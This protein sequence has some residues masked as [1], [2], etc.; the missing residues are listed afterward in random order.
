MNFS[1]FGYMGM[2][3]KCSTY[4]KPKQSDAKEIMEKLIKDN[5][6]PANKIASHLTPCML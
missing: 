2:E 4:L 6:T 1:P 5:E 3:R